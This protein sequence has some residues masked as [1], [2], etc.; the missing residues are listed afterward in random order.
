[1]ANSPWQTAYQQLWELPLTPGTGG[2]PGSGTVHFWINEGLMA[3]FF[4]S[5]GLEIRAEFLEG[6][7]RSI[8]RAALPAAAALGGVVFPALIYLA[9]NPGPL[10]RHGWAIPTATDI[11]FALAVFSFLGRRAP[12]ALRALLLAIAV[13]DDIVAILVIAFFYADGI[14]APG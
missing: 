10:V 9:C 7:L 3:V 13:I 14:G 5:V 8:R 11:A 1:W 2:P 6:D 12:A 4:L